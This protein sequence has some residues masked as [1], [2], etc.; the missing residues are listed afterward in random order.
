[1]EN[2]NL[3]QSQNLLNYLLNNYSF[4]NQNIQSLFLL[5]QESNNQNLSFIPNF[6]YS[7]YPFG[8]IPNNAQNPYLNMN[9]TQNTFPFYYNVD[10]N[11]IFQLNFLNPENH[12]SQTPNFFQKINTQNN[13]F[14]NKKTINVNGIEKEKHICNTN[15]KNLDELPTEKKNNMLKSDI[16][17]TNKTEENII[18]NDKYIEDNE[19]L[20][21]KNEQKCIKLDEKNETTISTGEEKLKENDIE[22]KELPKKKKKRRINYTDLLYDPLLEQIGREKKTEIKKENSSQEKEKISGNEKT[23]KEENNKLNKNNNQIK[24]KQKQK[25]KTGKHS[26]KKQHNITLK[27]NKDILADLEENKRKENDENNPKITRVIYHGK[28]YKETKNINDFM[29]YNFDFSVEEQYK[30]KKLITDYSQQ[31]VDI[32]KIKGNNNIYENYNSSEQHLDEIKNIW[33][34]EKFLGDNKELKKAINT[35]RDSYNERKIYTNE[36]KYLDII[37]NNNYNI[38]EFTNKKSCK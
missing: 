2:N 25:N 3:V 35:I 23:K 24:P 6:P 37:K 30:S 13:F 31:H 33:S 7:P 15:D 16:N 34:R 22:T 21:E 27:N 1:M 10:Y 28:D 18:N 9:N 26:K 4:M 36:E 19:T 20:D 11:N 38:S 5:L 14:L 12:I 17:V 8:F 32:N 29:K